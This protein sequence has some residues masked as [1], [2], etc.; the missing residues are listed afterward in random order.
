MLPISLLI[1]IGKDQFF[2]RKPKPKPARRFRPA[3][4][5]VEPR[6]SPSTFF[7][8]FAPPTRFVPITALL[9]VVKP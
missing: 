4:E 3:T 2:M 1:L 6:I 7:H 8:G 5:Q 9:P